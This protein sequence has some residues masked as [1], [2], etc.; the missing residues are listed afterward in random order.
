MTEDEEKFCEAM[1]RV[2]K[3]DPRLV[4]WWVHN[5][6]I[7]FDEFNVNPEEVD[8]HCLRTL[9]GYTV[10]MGRAEENDFEGCKAY[11]NRGAKV[12]DC[13]SDGETALNLAAKNNFAD[14]VE[15]LIE[16][17]ANVNYE[18]YHHESVT[19]LVHAIRNNAKETAELLLKHGASIHIEHKWEQDQ[20][21]KDALIAAID[22]DSK[23]LVELLIKYGAD[24]NRTDPSPLWFAI[25]HDH[26]EIAEF[27]IN[28]GAHLTGRALEAVV[29]RGYPKLLEIFL[30]K[31]V[32]I[33]ILVEDKD[34]EGNKK[35]KTLLDIAEKEEIKVMLR[36]CEVLSVN[37]VGCD[38]KF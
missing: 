15:L 12:D 19:P 16:H 32:N 18:G 30:R 36:D 24:V 35:V 38:K 26:E 29:R 13:S 20:Y 9:S 17:G 33:N 6:S 23:E 31:G 4:Y 37:S 11:L 10:L 7:P 8:I 1:D 25:Y 14:I 21:W 5:D 27:L 22:K 28:H 34:D 2:E 3:E